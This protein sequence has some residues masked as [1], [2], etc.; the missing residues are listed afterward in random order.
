[1]D[2]LP[3]QAQLGNQKNVQVHL[4]LGGIPDKPVS[5]SIAI[6]QNAMCQK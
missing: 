5:H 1:M 4:K 2:A 3:S 6:C